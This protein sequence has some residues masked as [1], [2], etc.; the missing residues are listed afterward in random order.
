MRAGVLLLRID[1]RLAQAEA[2]LAGVMT[3]VVLVVMVL[4][5]AMRA[6]GRPLI[7]ADEAAISAMVWAGFMGA[8]ALFAGQRHMAVTLLDEMLGETGRRRLGRVVSALMLAGFLGL[9][10]IVWRWFDPVGLIRAGGGQALAAQSFNYLYIEPTQTLGFAKVWVWAVLPLF[11]LGG[12][13]H[14]LVA[15]VAPAQAARAHAAADAARAAGQ[16]AA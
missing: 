6:T 4:A 7:W 13:V 11:A 14:A 3:A 15:L 16:A 5:T 10:W 1:R 9:D 2:A 8:A 12:T